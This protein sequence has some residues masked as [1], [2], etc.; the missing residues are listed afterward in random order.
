MNLT[1]NE[2]LFTRPTWSPEDGGAGGANGDTGAGGA[3]SD[4]V[5]GGGADTVSG[6]GTDTL[7]GGGTDTVAGGGQRGWWEADGMPE[8]TR[9]FFKANG[10]TVDDP[11]EAAR[12]AADMARHAQKL[13]GHKPEDLVT[14]PK[15]GQELA[16]WMKANRELFG[17][18]E[19]AEDYAI[20]KPEGFEGEWDGDLAKRMQAIGFE[21]G[22]P[23]A[24][25][26]ALTGAF[27]DHVKGLFAQEQ[28]NL[29]QATQT[30]NAQLAKDW[31]DQLEPNKARARQAAQV[32]A[33]QAG[34][35][36]DGL[37][38]TLQLMAE[39]TGDA[40]VLRL[41]HAIGQAMGDDTA[42]GLG[43]GAGAFATTPAEARAQAAALRAP[44]GEWYVAVEKGDRAA[45]AK[46]RPRLEQLDKLASGGR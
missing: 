45:M 26:K 13:V 41:F 37:A 19:K 29:A 44:G 14:R 4:T 9:Q 21:A 38:A 17:L 11:A 15:E 33:E 28:D 3:G 30:M 35:D 25:M 2:Q 1:L 36:G 31:G 40:N 34:M 23:P 18:P 27:A 10:L 5:A 6:G 43:K 42:L 46:L 22:V 8:E 20:E 7:A 39:K 12:K 16:D 24:A 32:I